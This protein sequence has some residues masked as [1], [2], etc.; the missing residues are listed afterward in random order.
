MALIAKVAGELAPLTSPGFYSCLFVVWK[1]SRSWRPVI[2]LSLLNRFVD[3]SHF[4]MET[5]LSVLLSVCQGDWMASIYLREAYLQVPVHP[6][7]HRFLRF[8]AHGRSYQFRAL[9]FGL[10]TTPQVFTRVMAPV[11]A[12]LH[13]LGIRMRRYLDDWLVQASSREELRDLRV[14]LSLCRELVIVI[15]PREVQLLPVSGGPVSRAGHRR[16]DF[17]G[18]SIARS[19]LQ[20]LVNS[21]R[22][23]AF[24]RASSQLMAVTTRDVVVPVPSGSRGPPADAVAPDLPPPLLGSVG[25]FDPGGMVSG[26]SLRPSV[27]AS[28]GSTLSR[29]FGSTLPTS[30]VV[31][32]W[33]TG[34]LPAF[35]PGRRLFFP[36]MP[37][38]CWRYVTVSSTS[39]PF[40]PGP[41]WRCFGDNVTMVA[42]LHKEGGTRSTVLNAIAQGILSWV[43]SLRIRLAPQFIPGIRNV[44]ADS[45]SRPHHLPGS[46]WFLN[47]EVF[48][49]LSRQWPVVI[50]LFATSANHRCSIYFS[51]FQDPLSAGMDALLQSW[52][53]L[54]AYAFPSWSILPH[55]LTKLRVSHR[56]LLTL[57]APSWPQ[58]PWFADL[59]QM[60]VAPPVTLPSRPDLF[61]Q[62]RS[63]QA[64]PSCL[65]TIQ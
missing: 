43:E 46:E 64:G 33:E 57:I 42:Y 52:D 40:Y 47:M 63:P 32:T 51:P 14:V 35:G 28:W 49:S 30:A 16:T 65:E 22:I 31:L 23:S 11:S 15:N 29:T 41:L 19:H 7:S 45:L 44:L 18:F 24:R 53:G 9:C 38:S 61:F 37:R 54:L 2:D 25:S 17:C 5:I 39:S 6:E 60:S 1:S 36:S 58:R 48:R 59:L 21:R 26:L 3:V 34:L 62:P 12:I 50:D 20:A 4:R 56:T 13:S 55:V 27:V 10:S 8:V